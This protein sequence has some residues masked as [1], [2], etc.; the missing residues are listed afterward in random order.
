MAT[1]WKDGPAVDPKWP[2]MES[3]M[4]M[5]LPVIAELGDGWFL[6]AHPN[7]AAIASETILTVLFVSSEETDRWKAH[8]RDAELDED[9]TTVPESVRAKAVEKFEDFAWERVKAEFY[10]TPTEAAKP[11]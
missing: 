11:N 1:A 8:E 4:A 3:C 6:V 2:L 7:G 9:A 10:P 5:T